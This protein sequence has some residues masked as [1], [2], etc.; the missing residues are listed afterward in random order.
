MEWALGTTIVWLLQFD[1]CVCVLCHSIECVSSCGTVQNVWKPCPWRILGRG[2]WQESR[3]AKGDVRNVQVLGSALVL[4]CCYNH[5]LTLAISGSRLC[6]CQSPHLE[7]PLPLVSNWPV[8]TRP[9]GHSSFLK[10][11]PTTPPLGSCPGMMP[12][13]YP[14]QHR[15]HN[16][17]P[18]SASVTDSTPRRFLSAEHLVSS[19]LHPCFPGEPGMGEVLANMC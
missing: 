8:L 11:I 18:P 19:S 17:L 9:P 4:R 7:R 3:L 16:Q 5:L 15:C 1:R 12:C 10:H 13:M 14:L 6:P 2:P